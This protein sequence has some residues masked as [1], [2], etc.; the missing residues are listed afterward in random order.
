MIKDDIPYRAA[1][2]NFIIAYLLLY[3]GSMDEVVSNSRQQPTAETQ[4]LQWQQQHSLLLL[5]KTTIH[6]SIK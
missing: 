1:A 6:I 2:A 5:L 4:L 3:A